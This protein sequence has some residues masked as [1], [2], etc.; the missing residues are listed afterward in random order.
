[1][2]FYRIYRPQVIEEIDNASVRDQL[3]GLMVKD[4]SKLPHAFF[5]TGPKGTGKTTAARVI[6][7][8]FNCTNLTKSG[9]CGECE[10]CK[11][12]A[13]GMNLDVIEMDAASNRGIDE[14]RQL[15]DRIGLMPSS[16]AYTIYIIDEV[17]ML[18]TEAFNALLKT[19]EE[20][21]PH[22][23]FV[24]A[25]TDAHK[26][27]ATIKSRCLELNFHK[28]TADELLHALERVAAAEKINISKEGLLYIAGLVDGSFR[29]AVKYLEQVSL[30]TGK[31]TEESLQKMFA[32]PQYAKLDAF[33]KLL[34]SNDVKGS[35]GYMEEVRQ[36]GVDFR[37]FVT[38]VLQMLEA[39]LVSVAKGEGEP[40]FGPMPR[41][42]RAIALF[43]KAYEE[44]RVS[45]IPQL[46]IEVAIIEFCAGG[47]EP[48]GD[49]RAAAPKAADAP[50]SVHASVATTSRPAAEVVPPAAAREADTAA[51]QSLGLL[52]LD[53]LVEH[54]ADFIAATKPTNHSV[55]G[56]LRSSRPKVVENG[57]VVIE[58]FYKFHQEKLADI[59]T[60]IILSDVLKKLFGEKVKIEIVLGKK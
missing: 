44:L 13:K 60:K 17:H 27:P 16:S 3:L 4:R 8:L 43:S 35:L 45:P 23:V 19:L 30:A 22:A 25:T 20:P 12:I 15:R 42:K 10:Q 58:A 24:L 14:I 56:V 40:K 39:E 31:I 38:F 9:P 21:P 57:I 59:Q 41:L 46:P 18:T 7:K 6:A 5:F 51:S 52:T 54:W 34:F 2:S 36:Q 29:D 33:I 48:V 1:M 55:A 50:R 53:K 37:S 47:N 32:T 26:V 49:V 11:N 28:A